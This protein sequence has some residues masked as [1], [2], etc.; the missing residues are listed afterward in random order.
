MRCADHRTALIEDGF[1]NVP[2]RP[3][4][5]VTLNEDTVREITNENLGV[6]ADRFVD[7]K[8]QGGAECALLPLAVNIP[9]LLQGL[10]TWGHE[11]HIKHHLDDHFTIPDRQHLAHED[12]KAMVNLSPTLKERFQR[13]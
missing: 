11:R 5:G 4:L 10:M 9:A 8:L 6:F 7:D 12:R 13:R 2:N 1:I 3:G